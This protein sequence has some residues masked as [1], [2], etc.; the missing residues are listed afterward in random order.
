MAATITLDANSFTTNPGDPSGEVS[1]ESDPTLDSIVPSTDPNQGSSS[2]GGDFSYEFAWQDPQN[3]FFANSL[4]E[5]KYRAWMLIPTAQRVGSTPVGDQVGAAFGVDPTTT[6]GQF[7]PGTEYG[8]LIAARQQADADWQQALQ[9]GATSTSAIG[10]ELAAKW[11]QI[12][13]FAWVVPETGWQELDTQQ[14]YTY[15]QNERAQ[16]IPTIQ[17]DFRNLGGA[18]IAAY[19]FITTNPPADGP[20]PDITGQLRNN[21]LPRLRY[22]SPEGI[23]TYVQNLASPDRMVLRYALDSELSRLSSFVGPDPSMVPAQ[24]LYQE[25]YSELNHVTGKGTD[26]SYGLPAAPET[27]LFD[28]LSA[29]QSNANYVP[30]LAKL[31]RGTQAQR[32]AFLADSDYPT[33]RDRELAFINANYGTSPK[34][35]SPIPGNQPSTPSRPRSNII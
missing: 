27:T 34:A 11:S 6:W 2:S 30:E 18:P 1:L 20:V 16:G 9:D 33:F 32:V 15:L 31:N 7:L 5:A 3:A 28:V 17:S 29:F 8:T 23:K 21:I 12:Q 14:A 19:A 22:A 24:D 10:P 25:L 35:T 13:G 26:V 4:S